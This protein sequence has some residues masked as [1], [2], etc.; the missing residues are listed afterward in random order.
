[1]V[2]SLSWLEANS[3][4]LQRTAALAIYIQVVLDVS[5]DVSGLSSAAVSISPIALS[6]KRR[7]RNLIQCINWPLDVT[8]YQKRAK[9]T[10][11]GIEK[12]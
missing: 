8:L 6:V 4:L 1:M 12:T 7:K 11:L 2:P 3:A 5:K 10:S 9:W